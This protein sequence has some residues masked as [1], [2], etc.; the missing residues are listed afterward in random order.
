MFGGSPLNRLSWL[1]S[2]HAFLNAIISLH[3][4]RWL[5]F[6]DGKPLTVP[7]SSKSTKQAIALLATEDVKPLLGPQPY[8]GQGKEQGEVLPVPPESLGHSPVDAARHHGKPAVFLGLLERDVV[9]S[10]LLQD[11]LKEPMLGVSKLR[12]AP[13]FAMEVSD[14]DL[15]AEELDGFLRDTE[16]GKQGIKMTWTEPRDFS[17]SLELKTAG[18]FALARTMVDWNFKSKASSSRAVSYTCLTSVKSFVRH[19]DAKHTP[20]G[21][22]GKYPALHCCLG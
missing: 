5:L 10:P 9:S 17:R 8:F 20:N 18:I 4:T 11:I 22:D 2:S 6:N 3:T 7:E 12:G 13:Y 19:A 15:S 1:R 21:V 14:L 16:P